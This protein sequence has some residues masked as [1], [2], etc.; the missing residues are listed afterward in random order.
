MPHKFRLSLLFLLLAIVIIG[1]LDSNGIRAAL[2][3]NAWSVTFIKQVAVDQDIDPQVFTPPSSHAHAG[4]L[5]AHQALKLDQ[6]DLAAAYLSPIANSSEPLVLDTI[7]KTNFRQGNYAI[8]IDT[9]KNMG[10]WFTLEQAASA[11]GEDDQ[12]DEK[13]LV[14]Q[15]AYELFPE[16]YA[17]NLVANK[18]IKA[19]RLLEANQ[20]EEAIAA[21]QALVDQFPSDGRPYGRLAQAYMLDNQPEL[22]I[23]A[24]EDGWLLNAG[25]V[26]FYNG[27]GRIYEANGM[28]EKA[29]FAYQQT[30]KI[31]S[32]NPEAQ[33]GVGRL[34]GEDE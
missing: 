7:A 33:Q 4:M 1:L 8:A 10:E 29:L 21:Y 16:R 23:Q 17:R 31:N 13:I 19:D 9:W 34:S 14:Y 20:V 3:N 27:A 28:N 25:N 18:M 32:G 26:H 24:I 22:A 2:A 6:V 12:L 5:L 30:L 15:S 11:L